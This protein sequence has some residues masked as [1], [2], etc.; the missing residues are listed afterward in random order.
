VG[1]TVRFLR[2]RFLRLLLTL[3]VVSALTFS[4]TSFLPGD[5]ARAVL[6]D[7]R[8]SEQALEAVRQQM[9]LDQPLPVR[10]LM[11]VGDALQGDL[12]YSYRTRRSVAGEIAARLPVTISLIVV[13]QSLALM[14]AVF[15][16]LL[17]GATRRPKPWLERGINTANTAL[18]SI[19]HFVLG[20]VLVYVFAIQLELFPA[21]GFVPPW[22][23]PWLGLQALL[24]PAASLAALDAATYAR[25]LRA[26]TSQNLNEDFMTLARTKGLA[27]RYLMFRHLLRPS[28]LPLLTVLGLN[29]GGMLGGA[30]VIES[31][32]ALPGLGR[33]TLDAIAGRDLIMVQG[34]VLFITVAY[35]VI[36]LIVDI[37]YGIVDPRARRLEAARG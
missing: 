28:S 6:G 11:W 9:R 31:L 20:I 32:F 1:D 34:I 25:I 27:P 29:L 19:P 10:Y 17:P 16:G 14:W 15:A 23:N 8:A 18:L 26:Q 35:V 30:V 2:A 13:A 24:L 22:Q 12:G 21:I 37:I 36:N 33:L 5:P 3:F 4:M 7:F